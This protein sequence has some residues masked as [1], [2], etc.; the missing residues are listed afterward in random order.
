MK[1][2]DVTLANLL[3]DPERYFRNLNT[4]QKV[5]LIYRAV[6]Q[7]PINATTYPECV[8]EWLTEEQYID[9]Y[10]RF[11][12]SNPYN[13]L[14]LGEK[15]LERLPPNTRTQLVFEAALNGNE[16]EALAQ[17]ETFMGLLKK[18]EQENLVIQ[19]LRKTG[20]VS[21]P[22]IDRFIDYLP[23]GYR[24]DLFKKKHH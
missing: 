20:H 5:Q 6:L 3:D 21:S 4:E 23:T 9:L 16:Q 10:T 17:P 8:A 11:A 7:D 12:K 2:D 24:T 13:T 18:I 1:Q 19:A 22:F 15:F 14:L